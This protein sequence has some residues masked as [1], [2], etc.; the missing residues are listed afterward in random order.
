[1]RIRMKKYYVYNFMHFF[2]FLE[3]NNIKIKY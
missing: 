3:N 2:L 1:M